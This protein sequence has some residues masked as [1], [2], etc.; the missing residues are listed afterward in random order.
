MEGLEASRGQE[1][2]SESVLASRLA[3]KASKIRFEEADK[4]RIAAFQQACVD[5]QVTVTVMCDAWR[6]V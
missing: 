4:L 5:P 2:R 1:D 6:S 3:Q